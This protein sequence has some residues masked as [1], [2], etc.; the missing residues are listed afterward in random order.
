[1][2]G[3]YIVDVKYPTPLSSSQFFSFSQHKNSEFL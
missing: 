2:D 3:D 1:L